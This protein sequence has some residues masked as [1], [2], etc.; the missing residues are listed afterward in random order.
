MRKRREAAGLSGAQLAHRVGWSPSK[1]SRMESG[2]R[3]ISV[4]DLIQNIE[5]G[6]FDYLVH[7][8]RLTELSEDEAIATLEKMY[9]INSGMANVLKQVKCRYKDADGVDRQT[10]IRL[11]LTAFN[12]NRKAI[13]DELLRIAGRDV[14][15]QYLSWFYGLRRACGGP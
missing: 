12:D 10:D 5:V 7:P 14:H 4:I 8:E 13:A 9:A 15:D 1:I 2:Q 6:K 3:E 11:A